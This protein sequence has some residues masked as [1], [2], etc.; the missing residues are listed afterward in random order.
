[1]HH[2]EI[3]GLVADHSGDKYFELCY[4]PDFPKWLRYY[5]KVGENG[6]SEMLENPGTIRP[7]NSDFFGALNISAMAACYSP[8][9]NEPGAFDLPFNPTTGELRDD[10]W[11]R[12]ETNDPVYLVNQYTDN[13]QSLRLL[14]FECGIRDEYNL[15]YGARIFAKKLENCNIPFTFE[16]FDDGHRGLNYR[17]D[18]SFA[19]LSEAMPVG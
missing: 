13:L 4:K 8:N 7:K 15:H 12:W 5:A 19:Q 16:E 17:L 2:P 14:Y 6:I 9:L 18:V 3:F 10:V 1:M 11:A